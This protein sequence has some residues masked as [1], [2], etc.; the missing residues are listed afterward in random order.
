M[1]G[2]PHYTKDLNIKG[3]AN[4]F[5]GKTVKDSEGGL[6]N[7]AKDIPR[8]VKLYENGKLKLDEIV[9]NRYKLHDINQA[10]DHIQSGYVLGKCIIEMC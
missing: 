4:N 8:Y 6:T 9:T 5:M 2:Q 1:V 10:I 3:V 7:P